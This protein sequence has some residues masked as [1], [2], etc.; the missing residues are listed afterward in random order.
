MRSGC[1]G[2]TPPQFGATRPL[3]IDSSRTKLGLVA[4]GPGMGSS[5]GAGMTWP[6]ISPPG[7][8]V[9]CTLTYH[10][11]LRI[12]VSCAALT[13]AEPTIGLP[14]GSPISTPAETHCSAA[15]WKCAAVCAAD[16][17]LNV[18]FQLNRFV[19]VSSVAVPLPVAGVV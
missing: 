5:N 11:P 3:V 18:I 7:L 17:P 9:V 14:L 12:W 19:V 6:R 1:P 2:A 15:P 13:V 4:I 16:N 10:W 8:A